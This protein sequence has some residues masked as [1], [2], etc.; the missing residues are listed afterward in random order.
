MNLLNSLTDESSIFQFPTIFKYSNARTYAKRQNEYGNYFSKYNIFINNGDTFNGK[1]IIEYFEKIPNINK[2]DDST[3]INDTTYVNNV[4]NSVCTTKLH[5]II[6]KTQDEAILTENINI[7]SSIG[8]LTKKQYKEFLDQ[9]SNSKKICYLRNN[10]KQ[11]EMFFKP[12]LMPLQRP[13]L[14]L[15]KYKNDLGFKITTTLFG[16]QQNKPYHHLKNCEIIEINEIVSKLMQ[17][18]TF[19]FDI[20]NDS[21][22]ELQQ[23]KMTFN[24]LY[25]ELIKYSDEEIIRSKEK[26]IIRKFILIS[27]VMTWVKETNNHLI[28]S[29]DEESHIG[30]T[31]KSI[32]ERL[33]MTKYQMIFE[34][35]KLILKSNSSKIKDI[36]KTYIVGTGIIYGHEENAFRY[37]FINAWNNPKEMYVSTINRTMPV[38]HIN[39]LAKLV[40]VV[41]RFDNNIKDNYIIAIEQESYG[42]NNIIKLVCDEFC[43]SFLVSKE[44]RLIIDQYKFNSFTWDLIC[45]NLT[46]D[47]MLDII[48]PDYQ[49]QRTPV[50]SNVKELTCEFIKANNIF[51][52]KFIIFGQPSHVVSNIAARLAQYYQV[53][54]INIP[55]LTNN[56]FKLLQNNQNEL[57]SKMNNL[58]EKRLNIINL[59][60]MF[61]GQYEGESEQKY[62]VNEK[63]KT[64]NYYSFND[65][66]N[67]EI[68]NYNNR[69]SEMYNKPYI[70][71]N[72]ILK[73]PS[74]TSSKIT[75]S[76]HGDYF[77]ENT[78]ELYVKNKKDLFDIDKEIN[79]IKYMMKILN[80]KYEE[81]E[82]NIHRNKGEFKN[83][84]LLVLIKESLSSFTC[85]NQGYILDIHPLSI[86][87]IEFI[88]DRD[89]GYPND[90]VLLSY[91]PNIPIF[92]I[93]TSC[94]TIRNRSSKLL[95]CYY[96]ENDTEI[97][98]N[99][100][101]YKSSDTFSEQNVDFSNF[102]NET[103]T[104]NDIYDSFQNN[105][106]N[107]YV[108][109]KYRY[110]ITAINYMV[111]YFINK[112]VN[113]LRLNVPNE[114]A[115]EAR[116][117]HLQFKVFTDTI[118]TQIGRSPFK[119]D[120][121]IN[122]INITHKIPPKNTMTKTIIVNEK[123]KIA[124][125]KLSIMK[126]QWNTDIVKA[127]EWNK[128]QEYKK[129][130]KFH[131]ILNTNILPKLL[132]EISPIYNKEDGILLQFPE[133]TL[134][135]IK[136]CNTQIHED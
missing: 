103:K 55:N 120:I 124:L 47:P 74:E 97:N 116:S 79:N 61:D 48:V 110:E 68:I 44:D 35:E 105:S 36:F 46:I 72:E 104:H 117:D 99:I 73:E 133:K 93:D 86:E 125:N 66:T 10:S 49:T 78:Y 130:V 33:P 16:K 75:N 30:I 7:L 26:G 62:I 8:L 12:H 56:Y 32:L 87:Q 96:L 21:E 88:F 23:A 91:N 58:F 126:K 115:N 92:S 100:N 40:F 80:N 42:F 132:K 52:L 127:L 123:L 82:Y 51:S 28:N 67:D 45:S 63:Y 121:Y 101:E 50:I 24:Y 18:S 38:F 3:N 81:Y 76:E 94:S 128:K 53:Q 65:Q 85:R 9:Q 27:T 4:K 1:Y 131:N 20:T 43:N 89:I 41:S 108:N 37:I 64:D 39:E 54:L 136:L 11:Y 60:A 84:N 59:I 107:I 112:G 111:D 2:I 129:S 109:N 113:I 31:Q 29:E 70:S 90:I 98:S 17:Y 69:T 83:Q 106:E 95:S 34:F 71:E 22:I 134:N 114:L 57:V 14:K 5:K 25:N 119:D 77:Q 102:I 118:I 19:I 15:K 13:T 6:N 135:K 122:P